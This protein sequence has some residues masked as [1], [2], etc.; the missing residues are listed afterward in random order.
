MGSVGAPILGRPRPL[1]GHRRA[2]PSALQ[3]AAV[4]T[5]NWEEPVFRGSMGL[6]GDYSIPAGLRT[7]V[8]AGQLTPLATIEEARPQPVDADAL[9]WATFGRLT[10]TSRV[11]NSSSVATLQAW[12][13]LCA[14]LFGIGGSIIATLALDAIR[15]RGGDPP[16]ATN[17]HTPGSP[18]FDA[19]ADA[20]HTS[21][22]FVVAVICGLVAAV[23][24][25]WY[26]RNA[27]DASGS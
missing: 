12:Q 8:T 16:S 5:L 14:V 24:V 2:D 4:Y 25:G 9:D 6:S 26:R 15:S 18:Q 7:R 13:V 22:H 27:P 1:P 10:V 3:P 11:S 17:T 23:V 21:R 20:P 19:V